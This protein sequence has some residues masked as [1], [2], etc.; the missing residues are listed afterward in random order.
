MLTSSTNSHSETADTD[1]FELSAAD[2][3][4]KSKRAP[5]VVLA[6]EIAHQ[7][8]APIVLTPDRWGIGSGERNQIVIDD[9]TVAARHA[10]I[11]VTEHRV[12]MTSWANATYVN[13]ERCRESLL[14]LGDVLT[15]GTVDLTIRAASPAE[16]IAHLPEVAIEPD[17]FPVQRPV[18][19]EDT[20]RRLD[21]LDTALG[22]LDDEF[23]GDETSHD[24]LNEL[25]DHIQADLTHRPEAASP[26]ADQPDEQAA[27]DIS[28]TVPETEPIVDETKSATAR[29]FNLDDLMNKVDPSTAMA[30]RGQDAAAVEDVED[31]LEE[32]D[33]DSLEFAELVG[34]TSVLAQNL[35]LNALRSRAD[36]VRQLD[37]LILAAS[38]SNEP[39][40]QTTETES[41]VANTT[42]P[43][44]QTASEF[45]FAD[46]SFDFRDEPISHVEAA[47][48]SEESVLSEESAEADGQ[49]AELSAINS[50]NDAGSMLASL[51]REESVS[52]PSAPDEAATEW[53]TPSLDAAGPEPTVE[54][55]SELLQAPAAETTVAEDATQ[56]GDVDGV[57]SRLAEMFDLPAIKTAANASPESD[58]SPWTD[59]AADPGSEVDSSAEADASCDAAAEA[60]SP[61]PAQRLTSWLD[62][63]GEDHSAEDASART[64]DVV[65]DAFRHR[66][67]TDSESAEPG[68]HAAI[69]ATPE[70]TFAADSTVDVAN[71]DPVNAYMKQLL[72][73]NRVRTGRPEDSDS[74]VIPPSSSQP[75]PAQ[76]SASSS[77][78]IEEPETPE[79][80]S[81]N[82]TAEA[83]ADHS[84]NWLSQQPRHQLDKARVRAETQ[85]LR[86]VANQ[87]ARS[88]V[89]TSTRRQLKLQV[90]VK[91]AASILMLGCGIAASMLGVS[92][93]FALVV[94][95]IGVY[96]ALD[97]GLT[98]AR[99]WKAATA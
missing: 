95:G 17:D 6:V 33:E 97:L 83:E 34:S 31:T 51:F 4:Q 71:D 85:T 40:E 55:A 24:Q 64:A 43:A 84:Q 27:L 87:T 73:R 36:A 1:A 25:I 74:Y 29:P 53:K 93:I 59:T 14:C 13:G 98:I 56:A 35:T 7:H 5:A 77:T 82:D 67:Q 58:L 8:S 11:I 3:E 68:T 62:R 78:D 96:F 92:M 44:A 23:A 99:H 39:A 49:T 20:L 61:A 80:S 76:N 72:A 2:G 90:A 69:A 26:A 47:T 91:A 66:P 88:A 21:E 94:Q 57:R 15:V 19:G 54:A 89:S 18:S 50:I 46:S 10:M 86:E 30:Q 60:N 32:S 28:E 42:P 41:R 63:I 9:N 81:I 70:P 48:C 37:E 38:R 75:T 52:N 16:L 79:A 45:D 65:D 12:V 22:L